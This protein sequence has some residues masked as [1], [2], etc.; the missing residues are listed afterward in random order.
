MTAN[1]TTLADAVQHVQSGMTLALGG[2]TLYR[3]PMAFVRTL[4]QRSERPQELTLL[5]FTA[6]I[7][8]DLLIGAG[9]IR[10]IRSAYVGLEAFGFAPMFTQLAQ[11][12]KIN[13]IEET[14]ASLALG[15]RASLAGIGFMPSRAWLGT[16]L[17]RLRP[18]VKTITD[19]YTQETLMA[20]PAI[21]CDV[22]VVHALAADEAGNFL[23]NNNLAIDSE[24][25][26]LADTV[27]VTAEEIVP[28]LEHTTQGT[29]FPYPAADMLI[30]AP[31]G[32]LP[33]SCYPRYPVDGDAILT[34]VEM[35][36][37]GQFDVY[38]Q[39]FLKT[40]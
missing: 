25:I 32:A 18:D 34:Y 24:L 14:E 9:C 19:P 10:T 5:C 33:T 29:I 38:L 12:G 23:L 22:V 7:E 31:Q 36:N 2:M 30:H 11:Q 1:F 8:S 20:F 35:C 3:R 16:D 15:I 17:P 4:L 28:R 21:P 39:T 37:Q 40:D 27:I 13:I 6:G 26:Y